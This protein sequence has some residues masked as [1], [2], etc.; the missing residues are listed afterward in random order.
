MRKVGEAHLAKAMG[1]EQ[2]RNW[3]Q[4]LRYGE[5]AAAKLKKLEDRRLETV[6][7]I[8]NALT[9]KFN[10][11]SFM[12]RNREAME[13]AKE[14]YTL[15]AMNHMRNLGSINAALLLIQSCLHNKEYEDAEHYARHAY[16]MI[17]EM[18]DNFIPADKRPRFLA[19][20]SYY[21]AVA[22]HGL[23]EAGGIS[24]EEKQKAG[25]EA[26]AR[27]REALKIHTQLDGSESSQ[28]AADMKVLADVLDY[29]NN[30]DDD[31]IP[32]LYEQ[33]IAMMNRVEGSSSANLAVVELNLGNAYVNRAERAYAVNDL[34][35][36][37]ANLE[38]ALPHYREAGR[39]FRVNNHVDRADRALHNVATTEENMRG[40]GIA[41]AGAA[42]A[43]GTRG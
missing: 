5:L 43:I 8:S 11:L 41:R 32:R 14:C 24:P 4:S 29:F 37:M 25:E 2:K 34:D 20:G 17:A 13:C 3:V 38:L 33:S 16:F 26:I 23:A 30:V 18:T 10:A 39:I 9:A 22:I 35:R 27:A 19:D 42:A 6:T 28:V 1:F 40:V 21:L 15:W 12:D 36:C 31:E 7:A